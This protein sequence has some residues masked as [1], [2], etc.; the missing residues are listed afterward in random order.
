MTRQ[1]LHPTLVKFCSCLFLSFDF[2]RTEPLQRRCSYILGLVSF[3]LESPPLEYK[4]SITVIE[5][6]TLQVIDPFVTVEMF[7]IAADAAQE[8]TRTVPH[9][10]ACSWCLSIIFHCKNKRL[11]F[12]LLPMHHNRRIICSY[13]PSI[14]SSTGVYSRKWSL[15]AHLVPLGPLFT[16]ESGPTIFR[17]LIQNIGGVKLIC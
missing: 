2:C 10:G 13:C 7:G 17:L 15:R 1:L 9:N 14:W 3:H 12:N 16:Y 5:H 6:L 4:K 8:R 11:K